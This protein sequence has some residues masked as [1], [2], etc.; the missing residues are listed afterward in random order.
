MKQT[1]LY[2]QASFDDDNGRNIQIIWD[3]IISRDQLKDT[4][5]LN[6]QALKYPIRDVFRNLRG[7][8][9]KISLHAEF[10]PIFGFITFVKLYFNS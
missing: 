4:L 3:K 10:M 1:F 8:S 5:S 2:L 7:K 9:I 6:S